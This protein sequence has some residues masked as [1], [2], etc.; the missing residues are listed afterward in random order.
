MVYITFVLKNF[1][2]Y[3]FKYLKQSEE[4]TMIKIGILFD[5]LFNLNWIVEN[6]MKKC[7]CYQNNEIEIK[8]Y[9]CWNDFYQSLKNGEL[10]D[11]I[12]LDV[13]LKER[14]YCNVTSEI[15][16]SFLDTLLIYVYS[17]PGYESE[18][19]MTRKFAAIEL[20]VSS[21]LYSKEFN[22]IFSNACDIVKQL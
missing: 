3:T 11:I 18:L 7:D 20:P 12:F 22:N 15:I 13:E 8:S 2:I 14:M 17:I 10:F 1:K 4:I 16:Y 21:S 19:E 6:S 9:T 5:E